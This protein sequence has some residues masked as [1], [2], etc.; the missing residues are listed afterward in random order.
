[1][2]DVTQSWRPDVIVHEEEEY[3][4]LLV[5]GIVGIPVVTHSWNSPA[6]AA[7]QR[8]TAAR[9]L[10][11]LWAEHH[12]GWPARTTGD[13]YLDACP[14]PLQEHDAISQ[15][16]DVITVR[17]VSFTLPQ[18]AGTPLLAVVPRPAAYLTLGT[19]PVFSTPERL[20]HLID[21]VSPE[22]ATVVVTTG[23]N[24]V[25]S[26]G[27]L[28]SNVVAFELLP[29]TEV[30]SRVDV[31][32]SQGGAGGTLGAIEHDLPHLIIPFESQS[33][34]ALAAAVERVGIDADSDP[35]SVTRRRSAAPCA[36]CSPTQLFDEL[37]AR[38]ARTYNDRQPDRNH[39]PPRIPA[40]KQIAADMVRLDAVRSCRSVRRL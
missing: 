17:P 6:R 27:E 19:V 38:Y 9:R 18:V 8:A 2:L 15:I 39:P 16:P 14:P 36:T 12:L 32:V 34:I 24:P 35:I 22:V 20:R 30:L 37:H 5:A 33:Q 23:P 7:A 21:A 11:S 4:T 31:V 1:M 13:L 29:Q 10:G 3:A 26:L 40:P 28:P 25:A